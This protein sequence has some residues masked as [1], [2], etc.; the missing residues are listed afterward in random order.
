M[1]VDK[2]SI[3]MVLPKRDFFHDSGAMF[4][5]VT[6]CSRLIWIRIMVTAPLIIYPSALLID[7][8]GTS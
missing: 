2:A 6:F 8:A 7:K 1:K 3:Y 4:V 5:K